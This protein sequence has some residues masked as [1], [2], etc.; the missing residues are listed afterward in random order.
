M[1]AEPNAIVLSRRRR[2]WRNLLV[3]VLLGLAA[4][5][6]VVGWQWLKSARTKA[7]LRDILAELDR[8]E[9]G[10]RIDALEAAR[11]V[12]PDEENSAIL[13]EKTSRA[14]PNFGSGEYERLTEMLAGLSPQIRLNDEQDQYCI[15][16]L[17]RM[18]SV[19]W[20]LEKIA[21]MPRGHWEIE[22]TGIGDAS[23]PL[24]NAAARL[25]LRPIHLLVL[26]GAQEGN[27]SAGL[28]MCVVNLHLANAI[29]DEPFIA[30]QSCRSRHVGTALDGFERLLGHG[31]L[32]DNE[33]QAFQ[34][35]LIAEAAWDPWPVG[36]RGERA[37]HHQALEALT[38]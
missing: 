17:E 13:V 29:G 6:S 26:V 33:L 12:V 2:R 15:D 24:V 23:L 35:K 30:S 1:V 21:Q 3:T 38:E 18:E 14:V 36:L 32:A 7:E 8:D 27:F 28:R 11:A 19:V 10:W 20:D 25:R 9:P 16:E 31:E 5:G 37:W 4:V 34:A 22:N